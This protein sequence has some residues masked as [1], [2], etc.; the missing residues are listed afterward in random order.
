MIDARREEFEKT[1]DSSC[2][3]LDDLGY[4]NARF[5]HRLALKHC[6]YLDQAS[7]IG[8][9]A[10]KGASEIIMSI[11]VLVNTLM[12]ALVQFEEECDLRHMRPWDR[13]LNC[14]L[15][16]ATLLEDHMINTGWCPFRLRYLFSNY[17]YNI[18]YYL[19]CLPRKSSRIPDHTRCLSENMC[20]GDSIQRPFMC[21][22]VMDCDGTCLSISPPMTK[23]LS[24]LKKGG[25]PLISCPFE[26]QDDIKL[27]VIEATRKVHYAAITH[28][29]AD[30]LGMKIALKCKKIHKD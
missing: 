29:W 23:I 30:G 17:S 21:Q 15:P 22:H 9:W 26:F 7:V 13:T 25:V 24:I 16:S 11:K 12:L 1:E 19:S 20:L 28:V 8:R 6:I 5:C 27:D 4:K 3:M 14:T 10:I 18:V 2:T